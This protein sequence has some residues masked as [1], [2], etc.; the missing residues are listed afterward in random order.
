M[1]YIVDLYGDAHIWSLLKTK[2]YNT[3]YT[4]DAVIYKEELK[5]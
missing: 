3:G 5:N 4:D 1:Q 2:K